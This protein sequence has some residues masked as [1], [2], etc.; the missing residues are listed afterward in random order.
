MSLQDKGPVRHSSGAAAM[1]LAP[2][3]LRKCARQTLPS[4]LEAVGGGRGIRKNQLQGELPSLLLSAVPVSVF[5]GCGLVPGDLTVS[6]RG[7]Y[8]CVWAS[9]STHSASHVRSN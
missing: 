9:A 5:V 8:P 1:G 2:R 4:G 3:G 7:E 6:R